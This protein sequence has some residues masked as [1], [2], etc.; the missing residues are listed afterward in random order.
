VK[1]FQSSLT[2]LKAGS[3][4]LLVLAFAALSGC[5]GRDPAA[6]YRAGDYKT[7][8]AAYSARAA[9]GDLDALNVVGIHYY[10]GLGAE[11]DYTRAAEA[12]EQAA[13][14]ANNQAQRNLGIMYLH[15]YGVPRDNHRA[16]GWFFKAYDSGNP[17]ARA[18]IKFLADNVTPN[19]GQ[20]ARAQIDE[21]IR[22]HL[23]EAQRAAREETA[24]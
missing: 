19:A 18:Y 12:F 9:A 1:R 6:A 17:H 15:G 14:G 5:G 3:I 20:K 22:T 4:V 8:L 21:L 10:L 2:L 23:R 24:P 13:L 16:Y 7:S 11:R